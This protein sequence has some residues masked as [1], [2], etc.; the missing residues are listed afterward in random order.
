MRGLWLWFSSVE[1]VTELKD[2]VG[3]ATMPELK[4]IVGRVLLPLQLSL[5]IWQIMKMTPLWAIMRCTFAYLLTLLCFSDTHYNKLKGFQGHVFKKVISHAT[6]AGDVSKL[7]NSKG[8]KDSNNPDENDKTVSVVYLGQDF[9]LKRT[10]GN[11]MLVFELERK[12]GEMTAMKDG[13]AYYITDEMW[14]TV[15]Y[16]SK[17]AEATVFVKNLKEIWEEVVMGNIMQFEEVLDSVI[18]NNRS[19]IRLDQDYFLPVNLLKAEDK[20]LKILNLLGLFLQTQKH[21]HWLIPALLSFTSAVMGFSTTIRL[22]ID[23]L[24]NRVLCGTVHMVC[25]RLPLP[26]RR[27]VYF[28]GNWVE[29]LKPCNDLQSKIVKD[30]I[31][32]LVAGGAKAH[33]GSLDD[34]ESLAHPRNIRVLV[35]KVGKTTEQ[36]VPDWNCLPYLYVPFK[37]NCAKGHLD[38]FGDFE[39]LAVGSVDPNKNCKLGPF[40]FR[41]ESVYIEWIFDTTYLRC[42]LKAGVFTCCKAEEFLKP[43]VIVFDEEDIK[44]FTYD[45]CKVDNHENGEK[46]FV[47]VFGGGCCGADQEHNRLIMDGIDTASVDV[48]CSSNEAIKLF[49][50]AFYMAEQKSGS[51]KSY[52]PNNKIVSVRGFVESINAYVRSGYPPLYKLNKLEKVV[53]H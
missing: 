9:V 13:P 17:V 23:S 46:N 28:W 48:D 4:D 24:I 10:G 53:V 37:H 21:V 29:N 11:K 25:D 31:C 47:S 8:R 52:E 43:H 49:K 26:I 7:K 39:S 15:L 42:S 12:D 34:C 16:I 1:T 36:K 45:C 19:V 44:I 20:L 30:N 6:T 22:S 51:L 18:L 40:F 50:L 35:T 32:T 27:R 38:T 2:V 14:E 3:R 41:C 33:F 5:G